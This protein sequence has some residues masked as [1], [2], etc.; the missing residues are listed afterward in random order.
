MKKMTRR[1]ITGLTISVACLMG[2]H[3]NAQRQMEPLGRGVVAMRKSTTQAYI[4]WRLLGDEPQDVG[5]KLYRVAGGVTNVLNGGGILTATTDYVDTPNFSLS[6]F[7]FV[8]PVIGGVEQAPSASHTLGAS[9]PIRQY[10]SW[11]MQPVTGGQY[12]PYDVKFCWVGDLDADGEYDY[13]VDRLSTT[14][15][16][17]QYVQAYTSDGTL[18]WQA[19]MGIWRRFTRM[20]WRIA[21]GRQVWV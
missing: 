3:A 17:R 16:S 12:G 20:R 1:I 18:L 13:V 14:T 21:C 7:Y 4:S 5:F 19:D 8:R 6:N 15:A 10:V 11:P 2:I 9:A